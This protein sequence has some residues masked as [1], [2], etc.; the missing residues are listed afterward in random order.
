M[1]ASIVAE[2]SILIMIC[3][4]EQATRPTFLIFEF[5]EFVYLYLLPLLP[6][7]RQQYMHTYVSP[8]PIVT[9]DDVE[10]VLLFL[11]PHRANAAVPPLS[12]KLVLLGV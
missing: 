10:L 6:P 4:R 7:I 2:G 3:D 11:V 5:E 8:A 12:P 1:N 9:H